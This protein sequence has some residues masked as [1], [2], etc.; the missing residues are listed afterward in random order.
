MFL[1]ADQTICT[2]LNS[3]KIK[4]EQHKYSTQETDA[5]LIQ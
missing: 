4:H 3:I 5:P 1:Q 2:Y